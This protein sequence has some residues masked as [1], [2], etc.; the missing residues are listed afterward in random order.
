MNKHMGNPAHHTT[1]GHYFHNGEISSPLTQCYTWR[2]C[3]WASMFLAE[4]LWLCISYLG[5]WSPTILQVKKLEVE[6]L[7]WH[8]YKW[9]VV[10]RLG[11]C[12]QAMHYT[13]IEDTSC[14]LDNTWPDRSP[15]SSLLLPPPL[16]SYLANHVYFSGHFKSC[17]LLL[18]WDVPD[19]Q[20]CLWN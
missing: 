20:Q 8:G 11:C 14:I 10:L 12:V 3:R 17:T 6:A 1:I 2:A 13:L 7:G 16:T 4:F 19:W 9:S 15:L 18:S 5:V